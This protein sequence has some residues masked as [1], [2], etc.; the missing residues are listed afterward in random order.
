MTKGGCAPPGGVEDVLNAPEGARNDTLNREVFLA[1]KRGETD[2]S[3][4]RDAALAAGLDPE[5]ADHT[6]GSASTRS[7]AGVP[8]E[9]HQPRAFSSQL[10]HP[11]VRCTPSLT[12]GT[13]CAST[14]PIR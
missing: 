6:I 14:Q 5:E 11:E 8:P 7:A 4:Y 2:F 12:G 9:R 10:S 3:Q 13:G 1:A